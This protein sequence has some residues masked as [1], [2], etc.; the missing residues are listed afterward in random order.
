MTME[1]FIFISKYGI[2]VVAIES[3][4]LGSLTYLN[5]MDI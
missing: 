2:Y 4:S 5:K 1:I 3:D